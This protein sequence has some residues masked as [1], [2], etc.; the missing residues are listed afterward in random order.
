MFWTFIGIY[1]LGFVFIP[2]WDTFVGFK[3][4][5]G[6]DIIWDGNKNPPILLIMVLWPIFL[7]FIVIYSIFCKLSSIKKKRIE[8]E[9]RAYNVRVAAENEQ[10]RLEKEQEQALRQIDEELRRETFSKRH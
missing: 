2:I 10:L 3:E 4:D 8:R 5:D 7:P 9:A 1:I 6:T